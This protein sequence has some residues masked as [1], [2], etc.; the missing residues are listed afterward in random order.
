VR[1]L[2]RQRPLQSGF[3]LR[4]RFGELHASLRPAT[5]ARLSHPGIR[6]I[7]N[8]GGARLTCKKGPIGGRKAVWACA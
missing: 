6:A 4:D 2:T 5:C 8:F 3:E 1:G 7:R